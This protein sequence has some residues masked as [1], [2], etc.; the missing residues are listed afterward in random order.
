M[1]MKL[2]TAMSMIAATIA[3]D[4]SFGMEDHSN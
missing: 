4:V 2:K 3:I 1:K